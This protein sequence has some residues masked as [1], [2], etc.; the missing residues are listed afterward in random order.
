MRLFDWLGSGRSAEAGPISGVRPITTEQPKSPPVFERYPDPAPGAT[1]LRP[2][3]VSPGTSRAID[4][5][6]KEIAG[7]D[8]L[9]GP[10]DG[11]AHC[12]AV[13]AQIKAI[14]KQDPSRRCVV[15]F[16]IDNTLFET[17]QRTL[18]AL[19]DYDR[20]HGTSWFAKLNG[21]ADVGL[22]GKHTCEL[23]GG[24][25]PE[26]VGRVQAHWM[27][28]FWNG[29]N[30]LRDLII[31]PMFDLAWQAKNAG[32]EVVYL[33]GRINKTSTQAELAAAGL[34]DAD[35]G[36][37]FCKAEGEKTHEYKLGK[38]TEWLDRGDFIGWFLTEGTKDIHELQESEPR[39]SCVRLGFPYEDAKRVDPATPLLPMSWISS[40]RPIPPR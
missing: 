25:P 3:K 32:A 13:L 12:Q 11:V 20:K 6:S 33:T 37:L 30:F 23:L 38:I 18:L 35:S 5:Q 7:V 36:H 17:R 1:M 34:P 22:D 9:S 40:V 24:I 28:F 15:V 10:V 14:K 4:L 19:R 27:D 21:P 8:P 26:E 31:E 29:D 39:V 16:D 2:G